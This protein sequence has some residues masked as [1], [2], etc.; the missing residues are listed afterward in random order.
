MRS[1]VE[2]RKILAMAT[3]LLALAGIGCENRETAGF[4]PEVLPLPPHS[5]GMSRWRVRRIIL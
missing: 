1:R 5:P 3:F 4:K 2:L